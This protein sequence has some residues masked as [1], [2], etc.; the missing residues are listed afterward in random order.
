MFSK[1]GSV[2][3]FNCLLSAY[4]ILTLESTCKIISAFVD[5]ATYLFEQ[6]PEPALAAL[7]EKILEP[8]LAALVEKMPEPPLAVLV[9]KMSELALAARAAALVEK[10]QVPCADNRVRYG[11][12][13]R[14]LP[15]SSS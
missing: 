6:I 2:V 4:V 14:S 13:K 5:V 11:Q 10:M 3:C 12:W 7:E 9:E 1:E 15:S 8:A